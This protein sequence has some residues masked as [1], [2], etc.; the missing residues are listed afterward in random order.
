MRRR[1]GYL[2]RRHA[3]FCDRRRIESGP[4]TD[5]EIKELRPAAKI[6]AIATSAGARED[7][8]LQPDRY[9]RSAL[10]GKLKYSRC[11]SSRSCTFVHIRSRGFCGLSVV[12]SAIS[13]RLLSPCPYPSRETGCRR[14]TAV[15]LVGES[16]PF[17]RGEV[18]SSIPTAPTTASVC[19]LSTS[20]L[21]SVIGSP[22]R[23]CFG[24]RNVATREM[25]RGAF[26]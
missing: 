17:T 16:V 22:L 12:R 2:F 23:P 6:N 9:E 26:V 20:F 4:L 10:T 24:P 13:C 7:S 21:K 14:T 1:T 19:L 15:G 18:V 3:Y 11:F 8:N 25:A 5:P